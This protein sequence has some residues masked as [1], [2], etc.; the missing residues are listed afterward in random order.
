MAAPVVALPPLPTTLSPAAPSASPATAQPLP[1]LAPPLPPPA[2][3]GKWGEIFSEGD[4]KGVKLVKVNPLQAHWHST[5]EHLVDG[6]RRGGWPGAEQ[7]RPASATQ[8]C[9]LP[10]PPAPLPT[11]PLALCRRGVRAGAARGD[12]RGR[13]RQERARVVQGRRPLP[14]GVRHQDQ[15]APCAGA[16]LG[17]AELARLAGS[18]ACRLACWPTPPARHAPPPP[19]HPQLNADA[20][21][22]GDETYQAI[23]DNLPKESGKEVRCRRRRALAA[24]AAPLPASCLARMPVA[25]AHLPPTAPCPLLPPCPAQNAAETGLDISLDALLPKNKDYATYFGAAAAR[26]LPPCTACLPAL[27]VRARSSRHPHQRSPAPPAPSP[28]QPQAP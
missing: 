18:N 28:A 12:R 10:C 2:P 11:V 4:A 13:H 6:A 3:A 26:Q 17:W 14:G 7:R 5:C 27:T 16:G 1:T 25:I 19:T 8:R 9:H 21:G 23:L 22:E 15:R 20:N 24:A